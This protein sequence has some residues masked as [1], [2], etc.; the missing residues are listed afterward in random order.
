MAF[1]LALRV[2]ACEVP[3]RAI[4]PLIDRVAGGRK[5]VIQVVAV[6]L[7][8]GG[9][10][11]LGITKREPV[12]PCPPVLV[13]KDAGTLTRI[14]S[15]LNGHLLYRISDTEY[16]AARGLGAA[17]HALVG[18]VAL[19]IFSSGILESLP[20]VANATLGTEAAIF[21][22]ALAAVTAFGFGAI[23]SVLLSHGA[24]N[25]P[26]RTRASAGDSAASRLSMRGLLAAEVAISLV[27]LCGSILLLASVRN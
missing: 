17:H 13:L 8:A 4:G 9:C 3:A 11:F 23:P 25:N 14:E 24:S 18:S 7:L 6:A 21:A 26:L 15:E 5:F 20:R 19:D 27:L 10:E 2:A 12:P 22:F 16:A 1:E